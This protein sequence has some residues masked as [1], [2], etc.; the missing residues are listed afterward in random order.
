MG[1]E[2]VVYGSSRRMKGEEMER[3]PS[4]SQGGGGEQAKAVAKHRA[5]SAAEKSV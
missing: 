2:G 1:R 5:R 3:A 4:I